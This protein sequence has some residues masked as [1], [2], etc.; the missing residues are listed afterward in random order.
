[1]KSLLMV[2]VFA[3]NA[4]GQSSGMLRLSAIVPGKPKG[5]VYVGA[6]PQAYWVG[7]DVVAALFAEVVAT[8]VVDIDK[9]RCLALRA[10]MLSAAN[11]RALSNMD[12]GRASAVACMLSGGQVGA[13]IATSGVLEEYGNVLK[14]KRCVPLYVKPLESGASVVDW[15]VARPAGIWANHSLLQGLWRGG[16]YI[17]HFEWSDESRRAFMSVVGASPE[18]GLWSRFVKA[19]ELLWGGGQAF[20]NKEAGKTVYPVREHVRK[21]GLWFNRL[22]LSGLTPDNADVYVAM[23]KW[24]HDPSDE[25]AG[26]FLGLMK[27]S[28]R[29]LVRDYSG[30]DFAS[31][32]VRRAAV[33]Q[34][35]RVVL[36]L[37]CSL[38]QAGLLVASGPVTGRSS[39]DEKVLF[40]EPCAA[41]YQSV[42]RALVMLR[43]CRDDILGDN[44]DACGLLNLIR[45]CESLTAACS[46][47]GV[48]AVRGKDVDSITKRLSNIQ[49]DPTRGMPCAMG[50]VGISKLWSREAIFEIEHSGAAYKAKGMLVDVGIAR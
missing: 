38:Y 9:K 22:S 18:W 42:K 26:S 25:V 46:K 19:D 12:V 10:L 32:E 45:L 14:G 41:Y 5:N 7:A 40:V 3:V 50:H 15:K 2:L 17:R 4:L 30:I 43:E 49:V 44:G 11:N 35:W 31:V 20:V 27:S 21:P 37:W 1:M 6:Q 36:H 39:A 34:R 29:E 24:L 13:A 33:R 16:V 8:V 48:V 47:G 23:D 28:M